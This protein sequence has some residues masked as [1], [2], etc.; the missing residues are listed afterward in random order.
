MQATPQ[1][2]TEIINP[3]PAL[4]I[5]TL[6][7]NTKIPVPITQPTPIA[8]KESKPSERFNRCSPVSLSFTKSV[9]DFFL[10]NDLMFTYFQ[11]IF[12][13]IE[14]GNKYRN[15]FSISRSNIS[16]NSSDKYLYRKLSI[17]DF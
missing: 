14:Q 1:K 11:N 15:K 3:G 10:N 5:A 12:S 9:T 2:T 4:E 7:V 6:P 16:L 13:N 17:Y 8:I